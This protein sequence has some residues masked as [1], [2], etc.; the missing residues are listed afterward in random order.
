M[1][2]PDT[3][4]SRLG[5]V[6]QAGADDALFLKQFGGEILTEFMRATAFRDQHFVRQISNG[7]SARFPLIGTV[8]SKM[9]TP[10]TWIDGAGVN[11]AEIVLTVDAWTTELDI[12][13][14]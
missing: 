10:G 1:A 11:T 5:Q 2:A 7:K 14:Q 4:L 13:R 3:S 12:L 6:N 9:H 8:S